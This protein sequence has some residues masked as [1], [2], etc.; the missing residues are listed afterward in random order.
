MLGAPSL[1]LPCV[2]AAAVPETM[3][4]CASCSCGQAL[5]LQE[6]VPEEVRADHTRQLFRQA[7]ERAQPGALDQ[8][9]QKGS[10]SDRR[11][12]DHVYIER[13]SGIARR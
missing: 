1:K 12:Q 3:W 8:A 13:G 2:V 10:E 4:A 9:R 11:R 7:S 5:L 6:P